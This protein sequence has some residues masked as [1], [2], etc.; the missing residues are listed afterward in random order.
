MLIR[1]QGCPHASFNLGLEN[2][3][4]RESVDTLVLVVYAE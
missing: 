1:L 4:P 2:Q 3:R